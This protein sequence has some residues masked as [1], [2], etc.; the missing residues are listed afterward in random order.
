LKERR[1]TGADGNEKAS[2]ASAKNH[3]KERIGSSLLS[4]SLLFPQDDSV[5]D[6]NRVDANGVGGCQRLELQ[7]ANLYKPVLRRDLST[8]SF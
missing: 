7:L 1:A 3:T 5:V 6:V 2:Y 8:V 4:N